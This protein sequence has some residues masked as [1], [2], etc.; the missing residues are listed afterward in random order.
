MLA[1][2]SRAREVKKRWTAC[3]KPAGLGKE[4]GFRPRNHPEQGSQHPKQRRLVVG[5]EVDSPFHRRDVAIAVRQI[6][7]R[8]RKYAQIEPMGLESAMTQQRNPEKDG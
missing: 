2:E 4:Q 8:V 3:G 7:D 5:K 1:T 6:P